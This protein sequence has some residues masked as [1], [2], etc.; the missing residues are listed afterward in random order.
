MDYVFTYA[1]ESQISDRKYLLELIKK[2]SKVHQRNV[3][4]ERGLN[5]DQ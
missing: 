2:R 1:V 3:S 5:F 4:Q